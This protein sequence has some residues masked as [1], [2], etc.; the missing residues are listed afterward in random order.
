MQIELMQTAMRLKPGQAIKI[1][2]ASMI[3]AAEGNLKSLLFD[4][5]RYSD[6]KEFAKKAGQNWGVTMTEDVMTG[7]YTMHKPFA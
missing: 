7:D 6:I 5:V 2:R 1:P 3:K 4:S